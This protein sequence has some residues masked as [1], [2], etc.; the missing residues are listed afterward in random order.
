MYETEPLV[1]IGEAI[2]TIQ[3]KETLFQT[4]HSQ[5]KKW[6][7]Y[8]LC[9]IIQIDTEK[10]IGNVFWTGSEIPAGIRA[11]LR[12]PMDFQINL[13]S[14]PPLLFDFEAPKVIRTSFEVSNFPEEFSDSA[15]AIKVIGV[16]E[17]V[18]IPLLFG[19]I[20]QGF[21]ILGCRK[22]MSIPDDQF[23]LLLAIGN[24]MASA[25][26]NT[27]NYQE[28]KQ[29]QQFFSFQLEFT[30]KILSV[31]NQPDVFLHLAYELN[32]R[33]EFDFFNIVVVSN[34]FEA[35]L[36][37][38]FL[39]DTDGVFR[40]FRLPEGVMLDA[41]EITRHIDIFNSKQKV[42]RL[43]DEDINMIASKKEYQSHLL[44][45]LPLNGGVFVSLRSDAD[46]EIIF[47]L[48]SSKHD[49]FTPTELELLQLMVPQL[50]LILENYYAFAEINTLRSQLEQEKLSLL[51]EMSEKMHGKGFIARSD[52]MIATLRRVKQVAPI[53]TTVL[54]QGETG[55]G[56]ELVAVALHNNSSRTK[57]P[58]IKVNCAALPSQLIESELFGHEKGSFTGATERRIGKFEL[59]NGGTIFLDEIGELPLEVQAKLLR[60]IQEKEFE[61]IGGRSVIRTDVRII[62]ATNRNLENESA[63]G[64]FRSDL[65]YRLNVFPI[66]IPPLRDRRDDIP[67]FVNFFIEFYCR[68][69]GKPVIR[70][71]EPDLM[72]LLDYQWP[73]NVRELEHIIERSVVIS[74]G[75]FLDLADFRPAPHLQKISNQL[76]NFKTLEELETEHILQALELTQGRV[77]GEKGAARLLGIN[78]KTLDSRMRKLGMRR[79]IKI[80]VE[81]PSH[82]ESD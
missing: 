65:F 75:S 12:H 44:N 9:G 6:F 30:N 46:A 70:V 35:N 43:N 72:R 57:G 80:K 64:R 37:V 49:S 58:L 54:I 20:L 4:I 71:N 5:L 28:I 15:E 47:F 23:P 62:A 24:L 42:L 32:T 41:N 11:E 31:I 45:K 51:G 14:A 17:T 39:K 8:H 74:N 3:E 25:V 68:R 2:A 27:R 50:Q 73:G 1:T 16:V 53:D 26:I 59:A 55:V 69:I 81:R 78:G 61:R 22:P 60:V 33:V 77:S 40:F 7:D 56:K 13:L 79:E 36:E 67:E 76:Q 18:Y 52:A 82:N 48:G 66:D 19:G 38:S 21:L 10:G 63:Q 34:T 29:R